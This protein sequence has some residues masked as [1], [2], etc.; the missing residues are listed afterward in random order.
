MIWLIAC[1]SAEPEPDFP[2]YRYSHV[3]GLNAAET[4]LYA[5]GGSGLGGKD[6][7]HNAW[8][9]DLAAGEWEEL[10]TQP[11][12]VFRASW[13]TLDD[14]AYVHAGSLDPDNTDTDQLLTWDLSTGSW[15]E[16]SQSSPR[17]SP[18][19]K[20]AAAST[21]ERILTYGGQF[22]DDSETVTYGELWSL[23][24]TT[25][26]WEEISTTGGPG[27]LTRVALAWDA[28]RNVLWLS[29]GIDPESERHGW[30]WS[31]DPD[32]WT[33]TEVSADGEGSG[34]RA[35]HTCALIGGVLHVWGGQSGDDDLWT[36]DPDTGVWTEVV[37]GDGP[38]GRDA[39]VTGVGAD[40]LYLFGGDPYDEE[41]PHFTN[42]LWAFD[43]IDQTW[44]E[45]EPYVE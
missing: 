15:S 33:W 20:E 43:T 28:A 41:I 37:T 11:A 40:T 32:T 16:I 10:E 12:Q 45:L 6:S 42:D 44:T 13:A 1:T 21:G 24:P 30:L 19:F 31:L 39:Q 9:Y 3:G 22:D 7:R 36:Y 17:P 25:T 4:H 23:D 2:V 34:P 18:R 8:R 26:T 27:E 29:G 5:A 35:S 38:P 14:V